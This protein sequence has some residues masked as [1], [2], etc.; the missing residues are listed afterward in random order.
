M[1][2][3]FVGFRLL[4][5]CRVFAARLLCVGCAPQLPS[6]R[7]RPTLSAAFDVS[8]ENTLLLAIAV[9]HWSS[10]GNT[11]LPTGFPMGH[12]PFYLI[13]HTLSVLCALCSNFSLWQKTRQCSVGSRKWRLAGWD[14]SR[15][16]RDSR[17]SSTKPEACPSV[18]SRRSDSNSAS[19]LAG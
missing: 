19:G 2:L 10:H 1:F 11:N 3:S 5:V 17:P 18:P 9:G 7:L 6:V 14:A 15:Q 4:C 13:V 12:L 16:A 8:K